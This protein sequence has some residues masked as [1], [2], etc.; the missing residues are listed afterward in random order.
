MRSPTT[1]TASPDLRSSSVTRALRAWSS[2]AR[3]TTT[4]PHVTSGDGI[5][6]VGLLGHG[7]VGSAFATMLPEQAQR[8]ERIT[9]LK[10]ELS[11]VLTRRMGDFEEI[12]AQSDL[13]VELI[14]GLEPA[15]EYVLEAMNAGR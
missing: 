7:T 5:F 3:A 1:T 14:G 15:R 13:I 2:G 9:G 10:P 12:L 11:G 6:R 4:W 8:I